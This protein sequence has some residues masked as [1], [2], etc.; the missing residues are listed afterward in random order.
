M[1]AVLDCHES[2]VMGI[3]PLPRSPCYTIDK[4]HVNNLLVRSSTRKGL[5]GR[6]THIYFGLPDDLRGRLWFLS[7]EERYAQESEYRFLGRR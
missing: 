2:L 4:L 3:V 1:Y 6:G 7:S 5:E